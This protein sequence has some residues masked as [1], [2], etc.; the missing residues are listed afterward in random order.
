MG[1]LQS[2]KNFFNP[3]PNTPGNDL[4]SKIKYTKNVVYGSGYI[5]KNKPTVKDLKLDVIEP[6]ADASPKRK[7]ILMVHGGSFNK[8]SKSE[9]EL[10]ELAKNF[11]VKNNY[12]CFLMDYRLEDDNPPS[13]LIFDIHPLGPAIHAA[14]VDVKT[15]LRYIKANAIRY[16]ID[17]DKLVIL[18]ESAGSIASFA[19]SMSLPTEY[20]KDTEQLP[21]LKNNNLD[22]VCIPKVII[23]FWGSATLVLNNFSENTQPILIIHGIKDKTFG[24][25][26]WDALVIKRRT[27]KFGT[28]C[29]MYTDRDAG[30]GCWDIVNNGYNIYQL[31]S[32]FVNKYNA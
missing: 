11:S 32:M 24:A 26:Y 22:E 7:C 19:A 9:K 20:I 5:N 4:D 30:H 3:K 2:I 1:I 29:T 8:G 23:D 14:V 13:P 15:A 17:P 12:V 16:N 10:V 27:M 6:S 21:I 31:C 28:P 18:G 25:A